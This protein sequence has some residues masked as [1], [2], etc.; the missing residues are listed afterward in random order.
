MEPGEKDPRVEALRVGVRGP[1]MEGVAEK[2]W[3]PM[4]TPVMEGQLELDALA[5]A[6]SDALEASE[7]VEAKLRVGRMVVPAGVGV[8]EV[9]WDWEEDWVSEALPLDVE[10][11]VDWGNTCKAR[12]ATCSSKSCSPGRSP[13]QLPSPEGNIASSSTSGTCSQ[14]SIFYGQLMLCVQTSKDA[15]DNNNRKLNPR[16]DLTSFIDV[17]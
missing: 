13:R 15:S 3:V 7:A 5:A 1:V 11:N 10:I 6:A 14:R 4:A 2:H 9:D 12:G 8:W 16:V 17:L